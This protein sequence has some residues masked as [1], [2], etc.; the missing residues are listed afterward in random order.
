M[1]NGLGRPLRLSLQ[2]DLDADEGAIHA[3]R[4]GDLRIGDLSTNLGC[5]RRD[6]DRHS[7]HR[8]SA[9]ALRHR[10]I[11][12][13]RN[14]LVGAI[15]AAAATSLW[16][17]PALVLLVLNDASPAHG[18][19][20]AARAGSGQ[21]PAASSG[22]ATV[23]RPSAEPADSARGAAAT[24]ATAAA[25]P[26]PASSPQA[27]DADTQA[28]LRECQTRI[29]PGSA[30]S[31]DTHSRPELVVGRRR[32][33]DRVRGY[34]CIPS[35][36]I[37]PKPVTQGQYEA[38]IGVRPHGADYAANRPV[39]V[40]F[41]QAAQYC[42]TVSLKERLTPCYEL[43]IDKQ[44]KKTVAWPNRQ[45]CSGY[46]LPAIEEA[47]AYERGTESEWT[48]VSSTLPLG[49][50][51]A[52]NDAPRGFYLARNAA[53]AIASQPTEKRHAKR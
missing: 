49:M 19:P 35:Y 5:P 39:F 4:F 29:V 44:G 34:M 16:L 45:G 7:G 53:P 12:P 32:V 3:A 14:G 51:D 48:W 28:E 22:K 6:E 42:N 18:K 1:I 30:V 38:V 20:T 17:G 46:R 26:T 27:L 9:A 43:R 41:V 11:A 50:L 52:R 10:M 47:A 31:P 37:S 33:F 15:A 40:S 13:R 25:T 23:D 21:A 24:A 2:R 36:A 8:R